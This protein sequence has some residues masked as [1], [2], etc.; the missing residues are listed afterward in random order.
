MIYMVNFSN[1][2]SVPWKLYKKV[3]EKQSKNRDYGRYI[4]KRGNTNRIII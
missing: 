1:T 3:K 4:N 2:P